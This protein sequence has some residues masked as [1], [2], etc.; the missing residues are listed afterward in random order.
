MEV[1]PGQRSTYGLKKLDS[2]CERNTVSSEIMII[3]K[4]E[5]GG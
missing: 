4:R 5:P 3:E 1:V 2:N